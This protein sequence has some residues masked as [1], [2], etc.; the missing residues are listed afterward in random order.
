M[1]K[2]NRPDMVGNVKD[3]SAQSTKNDTINLD[4]RVNGERK[5]IKGRKQPAPTDEEAE[6]L[7]LIEETNSVSGYVS[8]GANSSI[9]VS[10]RYG[11]QSAN[12][13]KGSI[14]NAASRLEQGRDSNSTSMNVGGRPPR[15]PGINKTRSSLGLMTAGRR[16]VSKTSRL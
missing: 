12:Q 10:K 15:A 2:T 16:I 4:L 9:S 13:R 3:V 14:Q 6:M 1:I 7:N 8:Q 11:L 5:N